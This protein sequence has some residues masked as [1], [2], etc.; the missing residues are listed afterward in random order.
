ML[1]I[2]EMNTSRDKST[3]QHFP[4]RPPSALLNSFWDI[5][6]GKLYRWGCLIIWVKLS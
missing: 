6:L 3:I 5:L 1:F 2:N 4:H